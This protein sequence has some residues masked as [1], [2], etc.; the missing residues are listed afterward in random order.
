MIFLPVYEVMAVTL[1]SKI[2]FSRR[3]QVQRI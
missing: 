1:R 2:A 3:A